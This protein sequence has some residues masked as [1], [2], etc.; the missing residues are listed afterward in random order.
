[1][2][3]GGSYVHFENQKLI[4]NNLIKIE[5]NIKSKL[6]ATLAQL[7]CNDWNSAFFISAKNYRK[8][9]LHMFAKK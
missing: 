6:E 8:V 1:M 9:S 2:S 7:I 5:E 4:N 3:D